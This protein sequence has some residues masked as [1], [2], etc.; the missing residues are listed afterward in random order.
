MEKALGEREGGV[1]LFFSSSL[2]AQQRGGLET[3]KDLIKHTFVCYEDAVVE[4][5]AAL[6]V[7][8]L[9]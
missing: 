2:L 1:F 3:T 5:A 8:T 9:L 7:P 4:A 6:G